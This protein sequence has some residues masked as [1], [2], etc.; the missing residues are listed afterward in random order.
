MEESRMILTL[1]ALGAL[2][3]SNVHSSYRSTCLRA[4]NSRDT[5]V[6]GAIYGT[7]GSL[8]NVPI[9]YCKLTSSQDFAPE[10]WS[11]VAEAF[12]QDN[13]PRPLLTLSRNYPLATAVA[14]F[15]LFDVERPSDGKIGTLR[16]LGE[17]HEFA[18]LSMHVR[19]LF[20][21]TIFSMHIT[22]D[23]KEV[24]QKTEYLTEILCMLKNNSNTLSEIHL[25]YP[26]YLP[27]PRQAWELFSVVRELKVGTVQLLNHPEKYPLYQLLPHDSLADDLSDFRFEFFMRVASDITDLSI[28]QYSS[29]NEGYYENWFSETHYPRLKSLRL[30]G[31]PSYLLDIH[32]FL[33]R[34][35]R[36]ESLFIGEEWSNHPFSYGYRRSCRYPALTN[37]PPLHCPPKLAMTDRWACRFLEVFPAPVD[38]DTLY[39]SPSCGSPPTKG[40]VCLEYIAS[41]KHLHIRPQVIFHTQFLDFHD[42]TKYHRV[43]SLSIWP[44]DLTP[45]PAELPPSTES[46]QEPLLVLFCNCPNAIFDTNYSFLV[47]ISHFHYWVFS[48]NY[49]AGVVVEH[50]A[51][52]G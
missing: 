45:F 32:K 20:H 6:P 38:L 8:S 40:Y 22:F 26:S 30:C 13:D 44:P 33:G 19:H 41:V 52:H 50:Y 3:L 23:E 43:N 14:R 5:R 4:S 27:S 21:Q 16:V 17:R 49:I 24:N 11:L 25:I 15:L 29:Y 1:S 2:N 12:C 9:S 10:L 46:I 51:T 35:P 7:E 36:I 34:H 18:R 37:S 47:G 42:G 39:I 31:S 28:H 48:F